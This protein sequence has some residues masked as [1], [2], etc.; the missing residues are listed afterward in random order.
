LLCA[1]FPHAE[2]A[3]GTILDG[4]CGQPHV[5]MR[6]TVLVGEPGCG[7]TT[8]APRLFDLLGVRSQIFPCGGIADNGIGGCAR[9]WSTCAPSLPV[10][11]VRLFRTAAPGI[12][13]DEIHRVGTGSP[14]GNALD[15][16]LGMLEPESARRWLDPYVAAPVDISSVL[17]IGTANSLSGLPKEIRDRCRVIPF[18]EP[19][20]AHI[21]P[22]ANAIIR[23][24]TLDRGLDERWV[25]RLTGN[26]LDAL[27][28]HWQGGSIRKLARLAEGVLRAREQPGMAN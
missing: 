27:V 28:G 9:K 8:F 11:L 20:S 7:K 21:E 2:Q 16:L 18:P 3:V 12:V 17:W 23:R 25:E 1:E 5:R 26:E 6:P 4:L 19:K 10:S 14:N 22:L 13:L 24:L 15:V